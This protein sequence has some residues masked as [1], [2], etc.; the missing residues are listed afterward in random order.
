MDWKKLVTNYEGVSQHEDDID[1]T[2]EG[3][4]AALRYLP[5]DMYAVEQS[6]NHLLLTYRT[7]LICQGNRFHIDLRLHRSL[8]IEV[9]VGLNKLNLTQYGIWSVLPRLS[10]NA[11]IGL[12]N[13]VKCIKVCLGKPIDEVP[14]NALNLPKTESFSPSIQLCVP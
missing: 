3:F 13:S 10:S 12:F 5:A 11:F 4:T 7:G 1:H 8:D 2:S 6:E 14:E 9:W